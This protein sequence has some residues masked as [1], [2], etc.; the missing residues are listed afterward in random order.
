MAD[1]NDPFAPVFHLH[2]RQCS[3]QSFESG[4]TCVDTQLTAPTVLSTAAPLSN[5]LY[6]PTS[7]TPQ[8]MPLPQACRSQYGQYVYIANVTCAEISPELTIQE[9]AHGIMEHL[10]QLLSPCVSAA[11]IFDDVACVRVYVSD[12]ALFHDFNAV[13]C[14]YFSQPASRSC[15]CLPLQQCFSPAPRIMLEAWAYVV[16]LQIVRFCMLFIVDWPGNGGTGV[17]CQSCCLAFAHS[18]HFA[19]G[20]SMHRSILPGHAGIC[21]TTHHRT[22]NVVENRR[23][24]VCMWLDK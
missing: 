12:M 3:A 11:N 21:S 14:Q 4:C 1:S 24:A 23:K 15:V 5:K 20:S 9:E 7:S 13:Y 16:R 2:V 18:K 19:L 6:K 8:L 22:P 17:L 10:K